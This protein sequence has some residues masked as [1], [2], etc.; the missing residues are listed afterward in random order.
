M[1][2]IP[3]T[4]EVKHARDLEAKFRFYVVALIF[5]ILAASIQ[6][7]T[8]GR[9]YV[10]DTLELAGWLALAIAGFSGLSLLEWT[11]TGLLQNT[12]RNEAGKMIAKL[13]ALK[14]EGVQEFQNTVTLE[15]QPVAETLDEYEKSLEKLQAKM[16]KE[17]I[18]HQIK[19]ETSKWS[20]V[21]AIFILIVSRS[22]GAVVAMLGEK[23][24]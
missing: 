7:A 2:A 14:D 11:T 22:I 19:Y 12:S 18:I 10:V 23:L 21:C 17:E 6:T 16:T 4:E 9:S 24:L 8:F 15:I 20:F 5:T 3:E 1:L 13:K